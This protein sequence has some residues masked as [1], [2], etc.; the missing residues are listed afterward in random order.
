[1]RSSSCGFARPV[2]IAPKSAPTFSTAASIRR[3]ASLVTSSRFT[4]APVLR[5]SPCATGST[6]G[7]RTY[8]RPDVLAAY[9]AGDV[10]LAQQLEHH[11]RQTVVHAQRDRGGVHH[12][13]TLVEHR[14]EV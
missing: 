8:Q 4:L 1:M 7:G 3:A 5:G 10:A 2:R 9:D 12:L 6:G 13:Q 11:D 14:Q